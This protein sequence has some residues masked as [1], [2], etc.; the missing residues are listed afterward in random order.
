MPE[1]SQKEIIVIHEILPPEILLMVFKKLPYKSLVIA[2]RT[3]KKWKHVIDEFKLVEAASCK[4][5]TDNFKTFLGSKI[6]DLLKSVGIFCDLLGYH[7]SFLA[8][9]LKV[10]GLLGPFGIF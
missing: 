3:C 6:L 4:F 10:L 8:S 9:L 1:L 7:K 5:I 2:R